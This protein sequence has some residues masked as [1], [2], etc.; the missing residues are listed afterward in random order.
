VEPLEI[1]QIGERVTWVWLNGQV[2][3]DGV[4]MENYWNRKLPLPRTGRCSCRRT[5]A[6]SASAT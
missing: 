4:V 3:V 1:R 6:R 2:A 5:A